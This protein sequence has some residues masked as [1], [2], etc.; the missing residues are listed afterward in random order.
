MDQDVER[1]PFPRTEAVEYADKGHLAA[2]DGE[3]GDELVETGFARRQP[4]PAWSTSLTHAPQS[5]SASG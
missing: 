1:L 5:I 3:R 4:R 2:R